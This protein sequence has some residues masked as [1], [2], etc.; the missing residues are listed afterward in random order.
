MNES[1][2]DRVRKFRKDLH[3]NV[4]YV[5]SYL[6]VSTDTVDRIESNILTIT[7][8]EVT[9]LSK[10]FGVPEKSLLFENNS[11]YGKISKKDRIEIIA[12][13]SFKEKL[14]ELRK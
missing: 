2:G 12:L 13:V 9:E 5:A 4:S 1:I 10:L 7:A 8:K 3:L 14:Q 6:N 11:D